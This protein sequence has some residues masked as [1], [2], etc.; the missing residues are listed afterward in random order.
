MAKINKRF[1]RTAG[2]A[3]KAALSPVFLV[4][5]GVWLKLQSH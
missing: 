3:L 5:E 4:I 2:E 1:E